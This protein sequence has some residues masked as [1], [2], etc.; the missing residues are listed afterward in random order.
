MKRILAVV[1]IALAV[2]VLAVLVVPLVVPLP[3]APGTVPPEQLAAADS[4]FVD[5][6]GLRV[7]VETA[8]SGEST[9]VLLHGFAASTYSWREVMAPL[10]EHGTVVAF[11]RPAF[12]Q[13]ER[14]IPGEWTGQDPYGFDAQVALTVGL[15]DELGVEK[16]V[17]VGNSAGGTVAVATALRY[18][19]RVSALVLVDP[20]IYG[21]GGG[22]PDWARP[23]LSSPQ[24][25]WYGPLLVRALLPSW[26]EGFGRSAW[27]DPAGLTPEMWAG[28]TRPLQAENWDRAF[29]EYLLAARS[30]DLASRLDE[31][32][33]PT[34]VITGDDD[35]IVPTA[36][37]VRLAGE[38]PN[39]E[40]VVVPNCGHIPHEECPAAF[41]L[42]VSDFLGKLP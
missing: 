27:H 31:V 8:G 37:S 14:P 42:A 26:G 24:M 13:T 9:L 15:L 36:Q 41:L 32:R 25:R 29:W 2:F 33:M 28:Y 10:A 12:G 3:P 19:E 4:R 38:L 11:D 7:H 20:A 6:N 35:R 39:A 5:V 30:P 22:L 17:L 34:L 18:P 21:H 40:L 1:L 23:I 16:A